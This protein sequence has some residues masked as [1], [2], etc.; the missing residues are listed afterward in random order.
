METEISLEYTVASTVTVKNVKHRESEEW[1][2][3]VETHIN[4]S[5]ALKNFIVKSDGQISMSWSNIW[6]T[7]KYIMEKWS[8]VFKRIDQA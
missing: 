2:F 3:T 6:V 8:L 5:K 4:G 7:I 1:K